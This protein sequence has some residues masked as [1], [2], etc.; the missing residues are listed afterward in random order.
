MTWHNRPWL[1]PVSMFRSKKIKEMSS[2]SKVEEA[3]EFAHG[4]AEPGELGDNDRR[5]AVTLELLPLSSQGHFLALDDS[6]RSIV[7]RPQRQMLSPRISKSGLPCCP[8][9][10]CRPVIV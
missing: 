1:V 6:L 3:D 2:L 9:M 4:G 5:E 10:S 7:C 8:S